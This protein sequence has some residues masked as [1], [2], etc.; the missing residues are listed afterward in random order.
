MMSFQE[1][2]DAFRTNRSLLQGQPKYRNWLTGAASKGFSLN[3]RGFEL[4]R[5]LLNELGAP[6]TSVDES[7]KKVPKMKKGQCR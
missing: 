7:T 5:N 4:A 1:Y 2:P 6:S 3:E